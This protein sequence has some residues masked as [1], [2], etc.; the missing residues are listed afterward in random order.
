M[1]YLS[2]R[3]FPLEQL[4][5]KQLECDYVLSLKI[6]AGSS[7]LALFIPH[8]PFE[9]GIV[10]VGALL[11]LLFLGNIVTFVGL[12]ILQVLKLDTIG[13]IDLFKSFFYFL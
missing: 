8:E 1:Q 11:L 9:E 10:E 12:S 7:Y 3:A 4:F 6:E 5:K 13:L 2:C